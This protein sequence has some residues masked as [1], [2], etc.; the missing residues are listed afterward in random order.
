MKSKQTSDNP[1]ALARHYKDIVAKQAAEIER[2]AEDNRYLREGISDAIDALGEAEDHDWRVYVEDALKKL[3]TRR[4][5]R[6]GSVTQTTL[7]E[8]PQPDTA[9][10]GAETGM[11]GVWDIVQ[12]HI[13][14]AKHVIGLSAHKQFVTDDYRIGDAL[15]KAVQIIANHLK[16]KGIK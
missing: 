2:L 13:D 9:D 8:P 16:M 14:E 15:T 10:A 6:V 4:D 5:T 1:A 12:M 3:T 7:S 11:V